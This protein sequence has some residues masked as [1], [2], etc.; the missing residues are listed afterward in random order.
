MWMNARVVV[1]LEWLPCTCYTCFVSKLW[2]GIH[3]YWA[4][5]WVW[6]STCRSMREKDSQETFRRRTS[7][8][9]LDHE[10]RREGRKRN[11]RTMG[12]SEWQYWPL[13]LPLHIHYDSPIFPPALGTCLPPKPFTLH[14]PLN[15][16]WLVEAMPLS[17]VVVSGEV[18]PTRKRPSNNS[19]QN[20]DWTRNNNNNRNLPTLFWFVRIDIA[21]V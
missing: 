17:G 2:I 12:N 10:Q 21:C 11:S 9:P 6:E 16:F 14:V 8:L 1:V 13:G 20:R 18:R 4:Q 3:Q 15:C 19:A 7:N 5:V